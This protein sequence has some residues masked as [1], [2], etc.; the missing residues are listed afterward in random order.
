MNIRRFLKK[1]PIYVYVSLVFFAVLI[2]SLQIPYL[3]GVYEYIELPFYDFASRLKTKPTLHKNI[4]VVEISDNTDREIG[5]FPWKNYANYKHFALGLSLL[6]PKFVVW[7]IEFVPREKDDFNKEVISFARLYKKNKSIG[8]FS[9]IKNRYI[10]TCKDE[11]YKNFSK[12]IKNGIKKYIEQD[13]L[14]DIIEM[15]KQKLDICL[16]EFVHKTLEQYKTGNFIKYLNFITGNAVSKSIEEK[17]KSD[18]REMSS[19]EKRYVNTMETLEKIFSSDNDILKNI[20][21]AFEKFNVMST[22]TKYSKTIHIKNSA[23]TSIFYSVNDISHL[24]LSKSHYVGFA[25]TPTGKYSRVWDIPVVYNLDGNNLLHLAFSAYA[26]YNAYDEVVVD[27]KKVTFGKGGEVKEV[28]PVDNN[29]FIVDYL[30]YR[31]MRYNFIDASNIIFLGRAYDEIF[32][33]IADNYYLLANNLQSQL[34]EAGLLAEKVL[35]KKLISGKLHPMKF[36][37]LAHR[38]AVTFKNILNDL[39]LE[40]SSGE[41]KQSY[42]EIRAFV[43][44]VERKLEIFKNLYLQLFG[45]INKKVAFIGGV[46]RG[47][48]MKSVTIGSNY[49]GILVHVS[50]FNKLLKKLHLRHFNKMIGYGIIFLFLLVAYFLLIRYGSILC[51]L[52]VILILISVFFLK[53][54]LLNRNIYLN[55]ADNIILLFIPVAASVAIK[56]RVEGRTKKMLKQTFQ[57][58]ISKEVLDYLLMY[59]DKIRLGGEMKEATVFF[60]DLSGF[61]TFSEKYRPEYVINILNEYLKV[62]TDRILENKG[63]LDKY[64]GDGVMAAFGVPV[65]FAESAECACRA[66]VGIKKSIN[67]MQHKW[68]EKGLPVLKIR[69]GLSTGQIIAGNIGSERRLDY[70]LIGDYVNLA[71]RLE[72][73]NKAFGTGIMI[74]E[75]TYNKVKD[76]FYCRKIGIIKVK[77]KEKLVSVYEL[78]DEKTN[79]YIDKNFIDLFNEAVDLYLS[80]N[81]VEAKHIFEKLLKMDETDRPSR[82][83]LDLCNELIRN[84]II[85]DEDLVIKLG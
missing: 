22:I 27:D 15:S 72:Q 25:N 76:K 9:L 71:N 47:A 37:K 34:V 39:I 6:K 70:T 33:N 59:P 75:N 79:S 24:I 54:G 69:I 74:E 31:K 21:L 10:S 2:F 65:E 85:R 41:D 35:T 18:S 44:D 42:M 1:I 57:N 68:Q 5:I 16:Y 48:D 43:G 66:S 36:Y 29:R 64:E 45:N 49:P 55:Y 11:D 56:E 12:Y 32:S 7:D 58:F 61:T 62:I 67:E 60:S 8:T 46:K 83:Y 28:I 19:E 78:I 26:M 4:V 73:S 82:K 40:S 17:I 20:Y 80:K 51:S 84:E 52:F 63:F 14:S 38:F 77:G 3:Q 23:N 53:V 13:N 81:I 30:D 50:S